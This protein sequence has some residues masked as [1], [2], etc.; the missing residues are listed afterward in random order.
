MA[1][2]MKGHA[3]QGPYQ[4]KAGHQIGDIEKSGKS[5]APEYNQEID[6]ANANKVM[7]QRKSDI[8]KWREKTKDVEPTSK[9]QADRLNQRDADLVGAHNF[10]ADSINVS[11]K[12]A[13]TRAEADFENLFKQKASG[14]KQKSPMKIAPIVA[15]L[16]PKVIGAVAG[17]AMSGKKEE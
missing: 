2:K 15:S 11:N 9:E 10:S 14:L 3:L 16:A 1:F 4:Q 8:E 5:G 6:D 17:K 13:A 12:N 7:D